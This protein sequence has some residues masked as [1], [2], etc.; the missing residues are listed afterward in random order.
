MPKML[1]HSVTGERWPFNAALALHPDVEIVDEP[2]PQFA[3]AK[4]QEAPAPEPKK[5]EKVV[6]KKTVRKK[7]AQPPA[8]TAPEVVEADEADV[9]LDLSD[10]DLTDAE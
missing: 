6:A 9:A 5:K 7:E 4:N 8:Q 3:A 2:D 10:I 1:V